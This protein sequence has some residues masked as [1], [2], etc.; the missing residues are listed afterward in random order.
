MQE[1]G[2]SGSGSGTEEQKAVKRAEKEKRRAE[3]K[4]KKSKTAKTVVS[5][6]QLNN[7]DCKRQIYWSENKYFEFRKF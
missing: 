3:R 7:R 1:D 4:E 2:G 6:S 5:P